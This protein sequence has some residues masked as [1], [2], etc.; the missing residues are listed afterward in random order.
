MLFSILAYLLSETY[1]LVVLQASCLELLCL[2]LD[3]FLLIRSALQEV[4]SSLQAW[5]G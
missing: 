3:L 1:R 4:V 5:F 2:T